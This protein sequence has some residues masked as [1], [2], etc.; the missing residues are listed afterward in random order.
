VRSIGDLHFPKLDG[1]VH[2]PEL[3]PASRGGVGG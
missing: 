3:T 2:N 1:A